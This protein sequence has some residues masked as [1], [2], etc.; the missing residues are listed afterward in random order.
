MRW[1]GRRQSS[2]VVDKRG[3][4]MPRMA[5]LGAGGGGI[6]RLLPLVFRVLGF[7]GTLIAIVL[8]VGYS[9]F[10]GDLQRFLGDGGMASSQPGSTNQPVKQSEAEKQLV[11]FVSTVL[12]DTEDSWN[13]L[14]RQ[15]GQS[16]REPRLVLFREAVATACGTGSAQIGPFYCPAD[17][18][19]YLDLSFFDELQ[20]RHGAPGDFAQAYVIAHEIGH[21]V[22]TLAGISAKVHKAKQSLSQVEAN[23][24]SVKQELQADCYAGIWAHD[25]RRSRQVLEAGDIEEGLAAASA[26]G[27]DRLQKQARGYVTPDSFTH[28]SS[29]QRVAWFKKGLSEG[30]LKACDTFAAGAL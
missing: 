20:R 23:R 16:Y 27:D 13:E 21:H 8:V 19:V 17:Q 6:M 30:T 26:I 4:R 18:K 11:E 25:A 28:G 5:R 7:K 15:A 14:F 22:Q 24:L 10:S 1:R 29:E 2:N 3:S 9:Y 12:A